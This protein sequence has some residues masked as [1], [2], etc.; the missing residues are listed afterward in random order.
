MHSFKKMK[1]STRFLLLT[2]LFTVIVAIECFFIINHSASISSQSNFLAEKQIPILNKA[3]ELKLSVV[4]VQQWLTDISATRGLDGLNDGF[5]EAENNAK[6]F[7]KLINELSALDNENAH[8]YQAML[9]VFLSYH[10]VG[11]Q[12]A[13]AYVDNGPEAGNQMM[14][15]FDEVAEKIGTDTDLLLKEIVSNVTHSMASQQALTSSINTTVF[16]G[17]F[18]L[19]VGLFFFYIIISSALAYLPKISKELNLIAKGDLSSTIDVSRTDEFGELMQG[20]Q[21]M[22]NQLL[23]MVSK[24]N[25]TV[26]CLTS[27]SENLSVAS[28]LTSCNILH[29][30]SDTELVVTAMNQ[31]TATVKEVAENVNAA[32]SSANKASVE[33]CSG[34]KIVDEAVSYIQQLSSQLEGTGEVISALEKDSEAINSVLSVI[35]GIAEQTNL[36]ALNAAIEA[37]RAGEQGR[38]FAVVADEVRTLAGRTQE[39]TIEINQIIERLQIGTRDSVQAMNLSREHVST[40]VSKAEQAG[41]SLKTITESVSEISQM[42][43]Q[44][45]TATEEQSAVAEEMNQNLISINNAVR[46]N[47]DSAKSTSKSGVDLKNK[48][49]ELQEL[50]GMF[51]VL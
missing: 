43:A 20:L 45:A 30:Q 6:L 19:A 18:A 49:R 2:S 36:L 40:A 3:H 37:A 50:V 7:K 25:L 14:A 35:Q 24:I 28:E 39:A 51:R 12:M 21:A 8:R 1:L 42:N 44:I 13:Q 47:A 16:I 33:T 23:N 26:S 48:T 38:G 5:D 31:M 22:Q 46:Q 34:Q 32:S 41:V 27:S 17:T 4:Q 29:Q 15:Q 10:E 11:T 9:P